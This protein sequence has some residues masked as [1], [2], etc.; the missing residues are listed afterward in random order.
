MAALSLG[1]IFAGTCDEDVAQCIIQTLMERESK[2]LD[3]P[4]A[5]F[6]AVGLGI[7]FIG[8]Q[9]SADATLAATGIIENKNFADFL[10]IVVE[11]F[12]Y[13]GSGNVLKIQKLLHVCAEHKDEKDSLNQ[14]AAVLGISMI[15]LGEDIGQDMVMRT[16]NHLLQYGEPVI[17]RTVPLAIGLLSACNPSV[18][19]MDLLCKLAYDPDNEVA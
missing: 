14:I 2:D 6:F 11:T 7:L 4:V 19:T 3:E 5:R 18:P 12:A 17:R 13:A 16:M 15:A 9:E 8:Q 1:L 10:N